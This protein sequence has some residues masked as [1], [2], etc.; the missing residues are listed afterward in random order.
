MKKVLLTLC[1]VFV[2]VTACN[3]KKETAISQAKPSVQK[4]PFSLSIV[5]ETS[6]GEG[7]GSS[8]EMAHDKP[9]EFYVV[10]TNSSSEPQAVWEHWNSWGYQT[11]SFELTNVDGKKFHVSRRPG[12]FTVNFP[13][14]FVISPGEHQV[15]AIRLD[16]W[17]ET[18]PPLPKTDETDIT[19][20]AIYE[21]PPTPEAAQYKV[22]TG[23]LESPTYN[24][25]LRQW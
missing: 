14:T 25:K 20:K 21:V 17:W 9:R 8:I 1:V 15:Y 23:R 6:R 16:Q 2:F 12:I 5:P 13:S 3:T 24:F 22:W 7:F 19:L 10:L 18:Q 11:V 4:V